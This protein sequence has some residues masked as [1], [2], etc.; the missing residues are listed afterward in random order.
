MSFSRRQAPIILKG[1]AKTQ[2]QKIST[3][4]QSSQKTPI[5]DFAKEREQ[6]QNIAQEIPLEFRHVG[7]NEK[8][9]CGSGKKFKK[10][11]WDK[12]H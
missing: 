9:P 5:E 11:C 8:C 7:R 6:Q 1:A 10:C 4:P 12:Y 3:I 2:D